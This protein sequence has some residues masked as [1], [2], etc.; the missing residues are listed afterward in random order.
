MCVITLARSENNSWQYFFPPDNAQFVSLRSTII[1]RPSLP[2][3]CQF[4]PDSLHISVTGS[5]SGV[6][7]GS[8]LLAG[9]NETCIF[10]PDRIFSPLETVSVVVTAST[11][12]VAPLSFTFTTSERKTYDRSVFAKI[13]D[14]TPLANN[15]SQDEMYGKVTVVNG[16][17]IPSDFPK[18]IPTISKGTAPGKIFIGNWNW[19]GERHYMMILNN[20]GS[21]YFYRRLPGAHTRDFKIQPTGTLTRRVYDD[22]NCFVEMDSQFVNI[23]TLRC[24]NGLGTDEHECQLLPDHHCFLIGLDYHS[25][26]MQSVGGNESATVIGNTVQELDEHNNVVFSW[27]SWDHFS[28]TDAVHENLK[29]ATIDYVHMNSI[30]V[31]YDSNIVISSRHLSEIT[32]INRKTGAIIWRLGGAHNQFTFVNDPEN[33]PSYQHDVRPVPG[34]PDSYT[35]MDNGNFHSPGFSRAVEYHLDTVAMTATKVWEYRHTPND[36][37]TYFMGNVQRLPNGNTFID[38][39]DA[40]TPKATEVTPDGQV[41]YEANFENPTYCYRAFRFPWVNV[42]KTPYL[43]AEPSPD[44]ITL[45]F[46]KFGDTTVARYIV[47]GGLSPSPTTPIDSTNQPW[48]DLTDLINNSTYYFRV[49]ARDNNGTESP[50]SNEEEVNVNL[51][52]RGSNLVLNGDFSLQKSYW[53]FYNGS[54]G[55]SVSYLRYGELTVA[56]QNGGDQVFSVQVFQPDIPLLKGSDYIFEFDAYASDNRTIV[57]KLEQNGGSYLNY[58]RTSQTVL[59]KTKTHKSFPFTMNNEN[60]FSA[61]VVFNLGLS[62]DTVW[63][64]NISVKEVVPAA[65]TKDPTLPDKFSFDQNYPNPFNPTTTLRYSL[66]GRNIR[67]HVALTVFNITGK[68]IVTLIDAHQASGMYRMEWNA[69]E[70]SSGIYF[71]ELTAAA[72]DGAAP[73]R[74][75]RKVLLVK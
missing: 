13:S 68:K 55:S 11:R 4:T 25:V 7:H 47:Y 43:I 71:I 2:P 28:I 60:D 31:D 34:E 50:F 32:K 38:W 12:S 72:E 33:G 42:M 37:Y 44:R 40:S 26:D 35:M 66:P 58:S 41:V 27:R 14:E 8:F 1:V 45:L 48:I 19:S 56:I 6:H 10:T 52:P 17:S 70:Y 20:D 67:Y 3:S 30:A 69:E 36:Y 75:V 74:A 57:A 49:T 29:A 54:G 61:R 65:V 5:E 51:V 64:D 63:L 23:D 59:T 15:R 9:D 24:G 53:Q 62:A 22:L 18:F 16:V 46:N 73:F 21:P 39:A